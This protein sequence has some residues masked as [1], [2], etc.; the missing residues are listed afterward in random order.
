[1]GS[2]EGRASIRHRGLCGPDAVCCAASTASTTRF[3]KNSC[4]ADRTASPKTRNV[5]A[6]IALVAQVCFARSILRATGEEYVSHRDRKVNAVKATPNV[7]AGTAATRSAGRPRQ[8]RSIASS[9]RCSFRSTARTAIATDRAR[10]LFMS[11]RSTAY[12]GLVGRRAA[13]ADCNAE[14]VAAWEPDA[15]L[16]REHFESRCASSS[17]RNGFGMSPSGLH[18]HFRAVTGMSPLQYQKTLRLHEARRILVAEDIDTATAAFRVGYN[19]SERWIRSV[20]SEC[21]SKLVLFGE[22][23]A[24][25]SG[26]RARRA[27][28]RGTQSSGSGSGQC[29]ALPSWRRAPLR[30]A[31]RQRGAK[32]R[33]STSFSRAV[34]IGFER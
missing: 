8:S 21:L 3:A 26:S 30:R 32:A 4:A 34:V 16:F 18:F 12:D 9:T 11:D 2:W 10:N 14:R 1:M 22:E 7:S 25:Q 15:S 28:S 24:P 31:T 19:V 13:G 6:S 27:L 5:T 33:S 29:A 23:G 17:S 20:K